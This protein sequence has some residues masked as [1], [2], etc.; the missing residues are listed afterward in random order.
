MDLTR[1]RDPDTVIKAIALL[2]VAA[3]FGYA[4]IARLAD[5]K[6]PCPSMTPMIHM[7]WRVPITRLSF[8]AAGR[9]FC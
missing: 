6:R 5:V 7:P 2:A 1:F 3:G 9:G 4:G 8:E